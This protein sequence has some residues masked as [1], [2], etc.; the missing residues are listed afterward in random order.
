[1]P[2]I[3]SVSKID[4]PY[5]VSQNKLKDF[6]R[7]IFSKKFKD[8]DR[9][10][11]SFDNSRIKS[12]NLCVPLDFFSLNRSFSEKN[13]IYIKDSLKYSIE[14]IS[15]IL[16]KTSIRKEQLT[17]LVFISST[18][19]S[20]PGLDAL[21]INE[22]RLDPNINRLPVWGLGCAGGTAGIAKANVI[23]RADPESL[24]MVI[25]CELCSLT[26][27]NED[28][29]K[30]NFIAT[31]LFSDGIAAVLIAGDKFKSKKKNINKLEIVDSQS[32]LYYDSLGVMGWDLNKDGLKVIFSRDIPTIV[33]RSVKKDILGFLKKNNL[34]LKDIKS[35]ITHPGGVKV[36]NAYTEA[37]GLNA[38]MMDN[39]FSILE[40]YGNMSSATVIYVLEK[41]MEK[42]MEPGYGL[43]MSLGPGFSSEL[44]LVNNGIGY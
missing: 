2:Q 17:D 36:I 8:I 34:K 27:L 16:D 39:T 30:S 10:L 11:K 14:A 28:L 9:L 38:G 23:A 4:L 31:S 12:R 41:F 5:K 25:C 29:S 6:S 19:I 24:V 44:V 40:E 37:L 43:I 15:K 3:I 21:I 20:T 7:S 26:F 1:M 33:N 13:K 42:K 18:G 22:M 32:R 35:F